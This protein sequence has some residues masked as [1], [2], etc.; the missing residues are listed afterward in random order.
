MEENS[1][2]IIIDV[3]YKF[4]SIATLVF[5]SYQIK[6][7]KDSN[8]IANVQFS[9]KQN[10]DRINHEKNERKKAIELAEMYAEELMGNIT[11]LSSIYKKC[12]IS[13]YFKELSYEDFKNFDIYELEGFIRGK[14]TVED[15]KS[16][17]KHIDLMI[18]VN[19]ARLLNNS[20]IREASLERLDIM[21]LNRFIK[22]Y[23]D[24]NL[25]E[26]ASDEENEEKLE[27]YE[28]YRN[29]KINYSTYEICYNEEFKSISCKT[30]N[31]LEYF[32]MYFNAG[33]ADEETV[34]QSLHQSFLDMIKVVYFSIASINKTGKDKYYT[35]IIQLYNNWSNRYSDCLKKEIENN[36]SN[37]HCRDKIKK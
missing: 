4:A 29:G 1:L 5:L 10:E 36:R 30:L 6:Q 28:Q 33:L 13:K 23:E 26:V 9:D 16:L 34:Y 12:G 24:S 8:K 19:S 32:C 3:V 31:K 21:Q 7:A 20:D 14:T 17:I 11:Y 15:M 27:L 35:N 25:D 18:L 22:G 2:L 37:T